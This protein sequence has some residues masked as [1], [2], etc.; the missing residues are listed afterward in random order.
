[1]FEGQ[2]EY[3]SALDN[4]SVSRPALFRGDA[5]VIGDAGNVRP[6]VRT[7]AEPRQPHS[8]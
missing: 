3:G 1:V 8:G 7:L 6:G 5:I 2:E 4:Y